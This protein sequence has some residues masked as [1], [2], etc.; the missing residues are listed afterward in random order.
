M[1]PPNSRF[2]NL[3]CVIC[4]VGSLLGTAIPISFALP[5]STDVGPELTEKEFTLLIPE[6]GITYTDDEWSIEIP[7]WGR[8]ADPLMPALPQKVFY[9]E[10]PPGAVDLEVDAVGGQGS[11][12]GTFEDIS[13]APMPLSGPGDVLSFSQQDMP[14]V[15]PQDIAISY[16]TSNWRGH[17]LAEVLIR[18]VQY[19]SSI[20]EVTYTSE[21]QL[22]LAFSIGDVA[23]SFAQHSSIFDEAAMDMI[24]NYG[25]YTNGAQEGS[26]F[27]TSNSNG[28]STSTYTPPDAISPKY[29][30][31]TDPGMVSTM[32]PLAEWKTKKG[33]P[34]WIN[35]TTQIYSD[36]SGTDNAEDIRLFLQDMYNTHGIEWVLLAGDVSGSYIVP[37]RSAYCEDGYAPDGNYVPTDWYYADLA[38]SYAPYDW[39]LDND[40]EFGEFST[41][42][43][44]PF[45]DQD[46][47]VNWNAEVYVGRLPG[48]T[49]SEM[50]SLVDNITKYERTPPSGNWYTRGV[51]AGA[52]SNYETDTNDDDVK[53]DEKT[54]ENYLSYIIRTRLWQ[55][56]GFNWTA[57]GETAG[58]DPTDYPINFSLN[59]ANLLP[60]VSIGE[61][62][63]NFAGHGSNTGIF[64]RVWNN[65]IDADGLDDEGPEDFD[66]SYYTTSSN[67]TNGFMRPMVYIDACDNGHFD[68]SSDCQSEKILKDVGIGCVASS[69][70]SWYSVGW[71]PGSDGGMYNQGHDFRFWEQFF[72]NSASSKYRPGASL[73]LSKADYFNDNGQHNYFYASA[74]NFYNYN[75]MGD[76]EVPIWTAQPDTL[77]V[78]H[79]SAILTGS[80]QVKVWVNDSL[81]NPIPGALVCLQ[82][83]DTYAVGTTNGTGSV[84]LN[85]DPATDGTMNVTVT[86]HDYLPYESTINVQTD[87]IAPGIT[88]NQLE[89]GWYGSDPGSVID[90]DFDSLGGSPLDFGRYQTPTSGW[91][92]IFTADCASFLANWAMNWGDLVEGNN[93]ITIECNDTSGN[94]ATDTIYFWRDTVSPIITSNNDSYGWFK[95]DP[96]A[97]IDIDFSNGS[98]GSPLW[99]ASY[100]IIGVLA[101]SQ[102]FEEECTSNTTDWVVNW[103]QLGEG[104]NTVN[105][106]CFDKAGNMDGT[107]DSFTLGKDTQAPTVS[108]NNGS[109]GWYNSDPGNVI[110]VDFTAG[111]GS[112]LN[113]ASYRIGSG[114]WT[115]IFVA[116]SQSYSSNW[117][118]LWSS[119]P[120]GEST[121]FARTF[122]VAGN[123]DATADSITFKKDTVQPEVNVNKRTYGWHTTDPGAIIDV[124]FS[125]GGTGSLLVNGSYR[126]EGSGWVDVFSSPQSGNTTNWSVFWSQLQEGNNTIYLRTYDEAG[127]IHVTEQ[128]Y[129]LKDTV[130]PAIT[131]NTQ[132]YGW[133]TSDPGAVIDVDFHSGSSGSDLVNGS[134]RI[135]VT[136]EWHLIFNTT[137]TDHT[138][139]WAVNWSELIDGEN[140]IYLRCFDDGGN[141]NLTTSTLTVKK[142]TFVPIITI[143]Q[144]VFGWFHDDPGAVFDI[145]FSNGNNGSNL[146]NASY[147]IGVSGSWHTIFSTPCS[148]NLSNW[149]VDWLELLEGNNTVYVRTFDEAGFEDSSA[150]E[151]YIWKD[152]GGPLVTVNKGTYGYYIADPGA[153]IDVDF[154]NGTGGSPLK[155]ASYRIGVG[156]DWH[157]IFST[158]CSNFTANFSINWSELSEGENTIYIRCFDDAGNEDATIDSVVVK[159]D[160]SDPVINVNNAVYEWY[161]SNPGGIFD[162]DFSCGGGSE[163]DNGSFRIGSGA[164]HSVFET[165]C[166][167]FNTNWGMDASCW[168]ELVEGTNTIFVRTYDAV[169]NSLTDSFILRIDTIAPTVTVNTPTYGWYIVD[170]GAVID[171]DFSNGGGGSQLDK[172]E[173][174]IGAVGPWLGIFTTD[175]S[176]FTDDWGTLWDSLS[177]GENTIYIRV[178]DLASNEDVTSDTIIFSKDSKDP[179]IVINLPSYGWLNSD[180]GAVIDVDFSNGGAGSLLDNAQYRIGATGTW[181]DIF[182]N[183]VAAFTSGWGI[184]WSSLIEGE[185]IV[186]LQV[187]DVAGNSVIGGGTFSIW[188][189]TVA[190]VIQV[191]AS[192]YGWYSSDPGAVIDVNFFNG[193]SGSS[194]SHAQYSNGNGT[195]YDIFATTTA[196]YIANWSVDWGTLMEGDASILIRVFD[197]AGNEDATS[198]IIV[199]KKDTILP[200]VVVNRTLYGWYNQDPGNVV[201]VDF[202]TT[203]GSL[204]IRADYRIGQTDQWSPIF[205]SPIV[206]YYDNWDVNWSR[207]IEGNNSIYVRVYD[208]ALNVAY[209]SS[210]LTISV[211][212][213]VPNITV[214]KSSYSWYRSDPGAV[215]E[216]DFSSDGG[217]LLQNAQYGLLDSTRATWSWFDIFTTP[218]GSYDGPWSVNWS[219]LSEGSNEVSVRAFDGGGNVALQESVLTLRKDTVAPLAPTLVSP[220]EDEKVAK[221]LMHF[222]WSSSDPSPGSGIS[223]YAL[224]VSTDSGFEDVVLEETTTSS[225]LSYELNVDALILYWRVVATDEAGNTGLWSSKGSFQLGAYLNATFDSPDE[226]YE[227]EVVRFDAAGSNGDGVLTYQWDFGDDTDGNLR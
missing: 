166:S 41:S 54:D 185:N 56:N 10:L 80:Q 73:A 47:N 113:N 67:P 13:L 50:A 156:G 132:E 167:D 23:T 77:Y 161:S 27:S 189:D 191:N 227:W 103:T 17:T 7:D 79:P 127:N 213:V 221:G 145:D 2:F 171:V 187:F 225:N 182:T 223:S 121:I 114:G 53:D 158:V 199:I 202:I 139:N 200:D 162:I 109:Y 63:M 120:E 37:A 55:P 18:P 101:W 1:S 20:H 30:I 107:S 143:N 44:N 86:V 71:V 155:N 60:Q 154:E 26:S 21:I 22:T 212:T 151:F 74:K 116:D 93:T 214:R 141:S 11:S 220:Q 94:Q 32:E 12:L 184:P 66:T 97:I 210:V 211:D 43:S 58:L 138:A 198:D 3:F 111:G 106:R 96:G 123:E 24:F 137:C 146:N 124:D 193:G 183:D 133:Y 204:L 61:S 16:G 95:S 195:W 100:N 112:D 15:Y 39:D 149:S 99:N 92:D 108:V 29:I 119:V 197:V 226:V 57:L 201:D 181:T 40:G 81:G 125:N 150:D 170:P 102:I 180:P 42:G 178:Y 38:G 215:I 84:T 175:T 72:N 205:S 78:D 131:I 194:L 98:T 147:R 165:N 186:Y 28:P 142:D 88:V 159:K 91:V 122:D 160:T 110:D 8:T 89:Y 76:P 134:Y 118:V 164:W 196:S 222:E 203:N 144:P 45:W 129:F 69:R 4:I 130:N 36:Y 217:S 224:Q 190:P 48:S 83:S 65:D 51:L 49:T 62:V 169:G 157:M 218:M 206:H 46:D 14:E 35:T 140:T 34:T 5:I 82:K 104:M 172:A 174:R 209:A 207:L 31:I 135:G 59:T 19:H 152:S 216:V 25:E 115:D 9:F 70:I 192:V 136:G 188:K 208:E 52:Y 75:L 176:L 6:P 153:V 128:I 148:E 33:V 117:S 87:F 90:V 177:E 85:V 68:H 163:L 219:L 64:R 173:Y 105:V 126:I 168:S 179:E